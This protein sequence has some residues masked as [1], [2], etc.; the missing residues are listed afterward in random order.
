MKKFLLGILIGLV[1]SGLCLVV[2][3][4]ALARWG[5]TRKPSVADGSILV[6][7]L[8]GPIPE[9]APVEFPLP[10]FEEQSPTTV[11]EVWNILR[12]AAAD[13]RIKAV[14]L[15]PS[16]PGAGW[17]KLQEIHA[18]LLRFRQSGKPLIAYLRSPGTRDYYLAT[19]AEKIYMAPEDLLD[20]K[21][22]RAE[23]TYFRKTLDKLGVQVEVVHA[24]KYKD[25][26]DSYVRTSMS[27]ETREVMNSVL[28]ELYAELT[29]K[30]AAGRKMPPAEV[31]AVIDNGPFLARQAVAHKLV[32][33][34]VYEDQMF[35]D[36]VKRLKLP[37]LKKLS[38]R[39]YLKVPAASLGLEGRTRI[40]LVVGEG[41]ILRS[42]AGGF[43][44]DENIT[45]AGFTRLL[46][47]AGDDAGI[48]GVIVRINSPGGDSFASD[49]IWHAMKQLSH[50]RPVVVS[51]SDL[52]A[53][54]GYYISMTGDPVVAY[55]GTFTGSIGVIYGKVNLRG[56][57]DKLG[58]S[59]DSLTRGRFADVDSEYQ[60]LSPAA[61]AKMREAVD[62]NYQ[63]FLARVAEG[64]RCKAEE[65]APLAEGRVWLGSQARAHGLVDE[66]GGL[67]K[68]IE[69]VKQKAHIPPQE[70]ITLVLYPA[71]RSIL[72]RLLG[73]SS[74]NLLDAR[75]RTLWKEAHAAL[76]TQGGLLRVM[77]YN[78]R[79]E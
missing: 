54:G 59:K 6:L 74:E 75:V 63:T 27:P 23:R 55:P 48:K 35:D 38:H 37:A 31:R 45:P 49:E 34:L 40:A 16:Q 30:V 78:L 53:S 56:L 43:D 11:Q 66:L 24:G 47:Q 15:M 50:K 9:R 3:V 13:A 72:E 44:E 18:C 60:P 67:D 29:G 25:Y 76:W 4:F 77:P 14:V 61:R 2:L 58:I 17:G 8:D 71:R 5:S 28:D 70:K 7:K 65:I 62:D 46:R 12:K 52:A 68:A 41:D 22:L 10:I 79:V 21:G 69:L 1:L 20:L 19:A 73:K 32:D 57:Y 36:L 64:R 51:M 42:Y 26:G 33:G 39:D